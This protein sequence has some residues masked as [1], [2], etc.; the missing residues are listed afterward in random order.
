M[1]CASDIDEIWSTTVTKFQTGMRVPL[2]ARD[3][4]SAMLQG[5]VRTL[6]G[7][8]RLSATDISSSLGID[9]AQVREMLALT[10]E[11]AAE[12]HRKAW[13]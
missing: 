9:L 8:R 11:E 12:A 1:A 6:A 4:S 7:E 5:K 10:G 2:V 3:D 13:R